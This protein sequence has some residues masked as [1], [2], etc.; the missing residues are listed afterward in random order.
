[1]NGF[2][3]EVDGGGM[4]GAFLAYSL[5]IATMGSTVLVFCYLWSKGRLDMDEGPKYQ[6]MGGEEGE[7]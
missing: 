1:M 5:A 7:E 2:F 3:P 4:V 6:M